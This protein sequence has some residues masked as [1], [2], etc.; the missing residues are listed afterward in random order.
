MKSR[1]LTSIHSLR[2]HANISQLNL[3][4]TKP[5][6]SRQVRPAQIDRIR[7]DIILEK[8]QFHSGYLK[9]YPLNAIAFSKSKRP[10]DLSSPNITTHL[11]QERNR[12]VQTLRLV[13]RQYLEIRL[14][15]EYLEHEHCLLALG[16]EIE[17]ICVQVMEGYQQRRRLVDVLHGQKD[18]ILAVVQVDL[19][20]IATLESA[21]KEPGS[22]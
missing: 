9:A 15:L 21:D 10:V 18:Q 3:L 6:T 1:K 12:V 4:S 5:L 2:L 7:E 17:H 8:S 14:I 13:R 11:R 19:T 22:A 20:L 16:V